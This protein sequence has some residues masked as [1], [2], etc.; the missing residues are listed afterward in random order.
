M[1]SQKGN[2]EGCAHG[3]LRARRAPSALPQGR[4]Y[5]VAFPPFL[6][7]LSLPA[8]SVSPL[9]ALTH[10]MILPTMNFPLASDGMQW[11]ADKSVCAEGLRARACVQLGR[12]CVCVCVWLGGAVLVHVYGGGRDLMTKVTNTPCAVISKMEKGKK[13]RIKTNQQI[14]NNCC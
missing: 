12:V 14:R 10:R 5:I 6:Y 8:L 9:L 11:E 2:S 13:K 3:R 1:Q 4:P 7:C